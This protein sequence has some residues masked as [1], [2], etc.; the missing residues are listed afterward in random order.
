MLRVLR[1]RRR[2]FFRRVFR[3]A[4]RLVRLLT[5]TGVTA[6]SAPT[7]GPDAPVSPNA[8]AGVV[9]LL[10]FLAASSGK[11]ILAGQQETVDWYGR[12]NDGEMN[13]LLKHTGKLPAVR[14]FDF[15]FYSHSEESRRGQRVA[16]RA[17]EWHRRGGLVAICFHWFAGTPRSHFYTKQSDF[18]LNHALIPG[19]RD[20]EEFIEEMD[21]IAE[22]LKLLRDA[23]V[24]VIWRPFHEVSGGWFWWGAKGPEPFK[25]A[26]R[27]MFDRFTRV[28]GLN[29]LIWCY[30]PTEKR[31][32]L[33]NWYPGDDVVD[34]VSLDVYPVLGNRPTYAAEYRRFR[35]FRNGR[36][37]VAL[38]ENG[39]I[40]DPD[41]LF[42]EGAHWPFFNTWSGKFLTD[43][44]TNPPAFLRRV[45]QHPRVITLDKLPALLP[46]LPT[47]QSLSASED[48]VEVT[49]TAEPTAST[50]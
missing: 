27:T 30:N 45:Y 47:S 18:N 24:P 13:Y 15:M 1:L 14:S 26:W 8:Q 50:G 4:F 40:P 41:R 48:D 29:N 37:V 11:H 12:D 38:T 19:T 44:R 32:A 16:E 33:E 2:Y 46:P 22:E 7:P 17:I 23:G 49:A 6:A 28:H 43:G 21:M 31:G 10:H 25:L 5:F 35:D 20:H 39:P 9:Q 3:S 42:A 36:K 34:M